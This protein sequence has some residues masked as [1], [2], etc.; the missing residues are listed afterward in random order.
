ME[1]K[2]YIRVLKRTGENGSRCPVMGKC[3]IGTA[4]NCDMRINLKGVASE[5]CKIFVDNAGRGI[6][7]NLT[8]QC[9]TLLNGAT[10]RLGQKEKLGHGDLFTV[11]DRTFRWEYLASSPFWVQGSQSFELASLESSAPKKTVSVPFASLHHTPSTNRIA[12]VT[13]VRREDST[14]I[15]NKIE[16]LKKSSI[17]IK[18]FYRHSIQ[19]SEKIFKKKSASRRSCAPNLV[20]TTVVNKLQSGSPAV[21]PQSY[22]TVRKSRVFEIVQEMDV[23]PSKEI[24]KSSR[25]SVLQNS[26]AK[27]KKSIGK[28]SFVQLPEVPRTP[29]RKS[30]KGQLV[31]ESVEVGPESQSS[32][33]ESTK[34]GRKSIKNV[35]NSNNEAADKTLLQRTPKVDS[36]GADKK[37]VFKSRLKTP[38]KRVLETPGS[39][40]QNAKRMKLTPNV[41]SNE[42]QQSQSTR[43]KS[44]VTKAVKRPLF[45]E[46][47]KKNANIIRKRTILVQNA[48]MPVQM[49]IVRTKLQPPSS[50]PA[51]LKMNSTGHAESPETIVIRKKIGTP[52]STLKRKSFSSKGNR[53]SLHNTLEEKQTPVKTIPSKNK[54]PK[55]VSRT[56]GENTPPRTQFLNENTLQGTPSP[57]R[58]SK[59]SKRPS[60]SVLVSS[61]K[62]TPLKKRSS[63]SKQT[64]KKFI[65]SDG[66]VQNGRTATPKGKP[67]PLQKTV[68]PK[69]KPTPLIKAATPKF[70]PTPLRKAATPK[71][72]LTPQQKAATPK[73]KQTPQQ[74]AATPKDKPTPQRKAATPKD[75]SPQRKAATPKDKSPQRKA[76]TPKDKSPQRKAVTPKDKSTPQRKAVTPK[77]KS[78]PQRKAVTPKDKSTPQR[79]AVTPKDKSTPQRKA[80]TPKDK[81]TPQQKAASPKGK[82]TPQQKAASPK[83]K[84]TP[85]QKAASPKGK[86]TPQQK[87]AS[88]KGKSTPQQKAA[89]PK[90]KATPQQKAAS[91]KGKATPQQKAAS[92][93]GKPTPQQK[94]AS[95]KG[96]STPQQKAASPKG[97]PTPQQKAASPK[98]IPSPER[99]SPK[100]GRK[101]STPNRKQT[102]Q[103]KAVTPKDTFSRTVLVKDIRVST[104]KLAAMREGRSSR[105]KGTPVSE[106]ELYVGKT[107]PRDSFEK[108]TPTKTNIA[109]LK[110]SPLNEIKST[111][112][113]PPKE[114]R[115]SAAKKTPSRKVQ[116]P[117]ENLIVVGQNRMSSG[118]K[119]SVREKSVSPVKRS[120]QIF[121]TST[122]KKTPVRLASIL[123]PLQPLSS[124][125]R[126]SRKRSA[127]SED[128][129]MQLSHKKKKTRASAIDSPDIFS[130]TDSS[131]DFGAIKTPQVPQETFVSPLSSRTTPNTSKST[132]LNFKLL[133]SE[134]VVQKSGGRK[135]V[136]TSP[137]KSAKTLLNVSKFTPNKELSDLSDIKEI[138]APGVALN[139]SSSHE[140]SSYSDLEKSPDKTTK[141][142]RAKD[143][144]HTV[145]TPGRHSTPKEILGRKSIITTPNSQRSLK[146]K[147]IHARHSA[148]PV[149]STLKDNV[150]GLET[151]ELSPKKQLRS[152]KV[153]KSPKNDLSDIQGVKKLL[154]TPKPQKSPQNDL[155]DVKGIK[156]L[157]ASPK[158]QKSPKNDLRDVRGVKKLLASPKVQKSP[159]ND[160][161]D[162]RGVKKL[163]A[164]PK[165]QKSPKNDLRDVRGVKK[166]LAS[167]QVQKS[168]KN[169][170][171]DVRGVK[172]LLASPKVQKSPKN[173]LRDVRGVKKLLASPKVQKS[174]KNDL[175]DV[176]GVKKL[177]STPKVQASPR[178]DLT[179]VRGVKKLLGSPRTQKSPKND[180]TD[181]RGVRKLLSSPKKLRSPKNDLTNVQGV[182][183]IFKS[184]KVQKS[185]K[186]DLTD[187]S[188]LKNLFD[189]SIDESRNIKATPLRTKGVSSSK[190]SRKKTAVSEVVERTTRSRRKI[191]VQSPATSPK[192]KNKVQE[193]PPTLPADNVPSPKKLRKVAKSNNESTKNADA[194]NN[195]VSNKV[196][197][198]VHDKIEEN[199]TPNQ[200]GRSRNT[201]A[202]KRSAEVFAGESQSGDIDVTPP[203]T[204]RTRKNTGSEES[205]PQSQHT[206]GISAA[207]K[208]LVSKTPPRTRPGKNKSVASGR[209]ALRDR[210]IS[211]SS[212]A[213]SPATSKSA[214]IQGSSLSK[215]SPSKKRG[216]T[217]S[218]LPAVDALSEG[219]NRSQARKS[220][221]ATRGRNLKSVVVHISEENEN[222]SEL[223]SPRIVEV[224]SSSGNKK[225]PLKTRGRTK[226]SGIS[227]PV[228]DASPVQPK[229]RRGRSNQTKYSATTEE[230]LQQVNDIE[231]KSALAS[232]QT[233]QTR[234]RKGETKTVKF[235]ESVAAAAAPEIQPSEKNQSKRSRSKGEEDVPEK[236]SGKQSKKAVATRATR[237]KKTNVE[238]TE[239]TDE[240]D[241]E[242]VRATRSTRRK[243]T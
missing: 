50:V 216:R 161:R 113:T 225:S 197:A 182:K 36:E 229:V 117:S 9:P 5:H 48:G 232:P 82:A 67:T 152:A 160:L 154:R 176:R 90:G 119:T 129:K 60:V 81:S 12:V 108:P 68:T 226:P 146:I 194:S 133:S 156:K 131:F 231:V 200:K 38:K 10:L 121:N 217:K 153:Q 23:V 147:S 61:V 218:I 83:G 57:Q 151:T 45:S 25:K 235:H 183:Q 97:K 104:G 74:K 164:S 126:S 13:P 95:P 134:R 220:P 172:K 168:P 167:P 85:Q 138:S 188:G 94:A 213:G 163:L 115:T 150:Q 157:L 174:P 125:G 162:V 238:V 107:T 242:N 237:T 181:V 155:N 177:I 166:L 123:S 203:K 101:S 18:K 118:K 127:T 103:P 124:T 53:K 62:H 4:L 2:G 228:K 30:I 27:G 201:R 110:L 98:N 192:V 15:E 215:K 227:T 22:S 19:G 120:S 93:K 64:L 209:T 11:S 236:Q 3:I 49:K 75:K 51:R 186:N 89:S 56:S 132:D 28:K 39:I 86:A 87:A 99:K 32:G 206:S 180:L 21:T 1:C 106:N 31:V 52:R 212:S 128:E 105:S 29:T 140:K 204:R 144:R 16:K 219:E 116:S 84:A 240:N 190:S 205:V 210:N 195:S 54:T 165:V 196:I 73:D 33:N 17:P 65:G 79:K 91:P 66:D 70:K 199:L 80:V 170:L 234:S 8:G 189:V 137:R 14:P 88:P 239:T 109:S 59:G 47:V 149:V 224:E 78:T 41:E 221:K 179:N 178:N 24:K 37:T 122:E 96:K 77:D 141:I 76:A 42:R 191:D 111:K 26:P 148:S 55:R 58:T 100:I 214:D 44:S 145:R 193:T 198:E 184:P 171:R 222:T 40:Q 175:T 233:K 185:P 20:A 207:E 143:I 46:M 102:P 159:K 114:K 35:S 223:S 243:K 169:D 139:S 173:D 112:K 72:K 202:K 43:G 158:V 135:S 130:I 187:V 211:E 230:P 63:A 69:F 7:E 92:P 142:L 208:N 136:K 71:E 6:I 241:S 34:K